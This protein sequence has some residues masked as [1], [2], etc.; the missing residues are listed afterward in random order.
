M[1][2]VTITESIPKALGS[3]I[4]IENPFKN[5]SAEFLEELEKLPPNIRQ[6]HANT[7]REEMWGNVKVISAGPSAVG[8]KE[9]D[10]VIINGIEVGINPI[11]AVGDK[12]LV[13]RSSS[14]IA[15]W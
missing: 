12:Y 10:Y 9:G 14:C 1:S 6:E 4:L 2:E 11:T 15:V 5:L 7:K 8:I 13:I 3:Y